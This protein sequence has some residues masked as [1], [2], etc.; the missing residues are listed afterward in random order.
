MEHDTED[1]TWQQ[2]ITEL[3]GDNCRAFLAQD[4]ERLNELWSDELIVNS[5]IN[6]IFEK[7]RVLDLLR[8]GVI[9]HS[10]LESRIEVIRRHGDIVVVM[11][12]ESV[13]NSP[14]GPIFRRRFTNL[15]RMEG[16]SWRLFI[17]HANISAEPGQ[18]A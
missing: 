18:N 7:Q 14:A 16:G 13:A 11:G 15:W 10:L 17:R 2:R 9:A 12:G 4:I 3:E 5:P 1:S 8:A 6:Q